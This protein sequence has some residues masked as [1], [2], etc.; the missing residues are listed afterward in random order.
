M[1][2][3][4]CTILRHS[5]PLFHVKRYTISF[6]N[7]FF[8]FWTFDFCCCMSITPYCYILN[9]ERLIAF[10]HFIKTPFLNQTSRWTAPFSKIKNTL[11][12][13]SQFNSKITIMIQIRF[14]EIKTQCLPIHW[15]AMVSFCLSVGVS[16]CL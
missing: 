12:F 7:L 9:S 3:S 11:D 5:T 1:Y 13:S 2:Y 6:V 10:S 16:V 14:S 4:C 15:E 8:K